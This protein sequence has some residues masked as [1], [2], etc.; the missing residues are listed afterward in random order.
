MGTEKERDRG[1]VGIK[2]HRD[3]EAMRTVGTEGQGDRRTM[4]AEEQ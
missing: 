2:G 4:G 3:T 1:T